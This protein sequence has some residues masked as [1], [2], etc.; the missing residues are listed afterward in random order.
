LLCMLCV[1]SDRH[2]SVFANGFANVPE[3]RV[4]Q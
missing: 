1:A 4:Q 3:A 2:H